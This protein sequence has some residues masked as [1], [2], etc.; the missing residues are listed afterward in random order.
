MCKPYA[1]DYNFKYMHTYVHIHTF[2]H[3]ALAMRCIRSLVEQKNYG[4]F[5][6]IMLKS[7]PVLIIGVSTTY[8]SIYIHTYIC[9]HS[10]LPPA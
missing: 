3:E 7:I 10:G 5:S 8:L 9:T 6:S 2:F 1:I 4:N